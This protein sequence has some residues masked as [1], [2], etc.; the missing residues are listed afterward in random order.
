[1]YAGFC[2]YN[3]NNEQVGKN[4]MR[5]D[6]AIEILRAVCKPTCTVTDLDLS[7]SSNI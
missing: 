7:V 5:Q 2:L 6:G 3:I 1:M 4:P